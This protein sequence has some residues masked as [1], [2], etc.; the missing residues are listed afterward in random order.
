MDCIGNQHTSVDSIGDRH[1][2]TSADQ[3]EAV[4]A[5]LASCLTPGDV[6]LVRGE[7]GAGKTTLIR[8]ALRALGVTE[9][10]MSPTYA[11]GTIY[12]ATE[13]SVAH[14][15]LYR[16]GSTHGEDPGLFQPYFD[17]ATISFVEWPEN[18]VV[19]WLDEDTR[20]IELELTHG[21]EDHREIRIWAGD[22]ITGR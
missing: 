11:I 2:S 12:T 4:G 5:R 17:S 1:A 16:L 13:G 22:K 9:Q 6:V 10:V 7:L 15:D 20:V 3:T 8:G 19:D 14:L 21:G 18:G